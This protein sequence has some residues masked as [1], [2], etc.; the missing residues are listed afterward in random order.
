MYGTIIGLPGKSFLVHGSIRV[1]IKETAV[2]GFHLFYGRRG[3]FNQCFGQFL[4]VDKMTAFQCIL[5][6]LHMRIIGIEDHIEPALD[7][8]TAT[9]FPPQSFGDDQNVQVRIGIKSI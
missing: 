1:A 5:K 8:A 4:I 6:M 9:A 3:L 2:P 7:H